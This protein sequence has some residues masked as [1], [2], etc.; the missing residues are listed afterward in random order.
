[1]LPFKRLLS[2][3]SAIVVMSCGSSP[4]PRSP[5]RAVSP[6]ISPPVPVAGLDAA[7][8]DGV[9]SVSAGWSHSCALCKTGE[10]ACW[11]TNFLGNLGVPL[12]TERSTPAV[13]AGLKGVKE[14]AAGSYHTCARLASGRVTCWGANNDGQL[15]DDTSATR[16]HPVLVSDLDDA[17]QIDVGLGPDQRRE[18]L[19]DRGMILD[20]DEVDHGD[21]PRCP[22]A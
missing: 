5:T 12:P 6:R 15:G 20:D 18:R 7:C 4:S 1:M 10:V 9:A 3:A 17:Q 13:I 16:L 14:I 11:G 2:A 21:G 19:G 8:R 22:G